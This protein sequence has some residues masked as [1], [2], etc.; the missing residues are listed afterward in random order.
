[1]MKDKDIHIGD[2][3]MIRSW[4]DMLNDGF[5]TEDG[6]ISFRYSFNDIE[7]SANMRHLCGRMFT[8][9]CKMDNYF[10]GRTIYMSDERVER[11]GIRG[12]LPWLITADMLEP[13]RGGI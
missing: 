3:L 12:H 2:V 9:I 5:L 8:V 11:D 1:M 4:E 10:L 13:Y 6:H 7:F